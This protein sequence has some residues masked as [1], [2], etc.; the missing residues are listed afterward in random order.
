LIE[1]PILNHF[2]KMNFSIFSKKMFSEGLRV[3]GVDI[4]TNRA[5]RYSTDTLLGALFPRDLESRG[6]VLLAL[7]FNEREYIETVENFVQ[8]AS[9]QTG[10]PRKALY[11]QFAFPPRARRNGRK[12]EDEEKRV[13]VT[14]KPV[15]E[16]QALASRMFHITE[17]KRT[18]KEEAEEEEEEDDL[19][20][21]EEDSDEEDDE[22]IVGQ[23]AVPPKEKEEAD[24]IE[25]AIVP[26]SL[27]P[28]PPFHLSW[29]EIGACGEAL[30]G[31]GVM[32]GALD[33]RTDAALC[34]A[35]RRASMP[36]IEKLLDLGRKGERSFGVAQRAEELGIDISHTTS[37]QLGKEAIALYREIYGESP[38][39]RLVRN[40]HGRECTM[41]VYPE[42]RAARTVDH[43]LTEQK[44][45]RARKNRQ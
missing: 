29:D 15:K 41:Y 13:Y 30:H 28:F 35:L 12:R 8:V 45:K 22:V 4:P 23:R 43:V 1:S 5:G 19:F 21:M 25:E 32:L 24:E 20:D 10:I 37:A 42:S 7:P 44:R 36:L 18:Q 40:A 38:A 34:A 17:R 9:D 33:Q 27:P 2:S 16:R 31:I 14:G 6:R 11:E 39:Q 3:N 26:L